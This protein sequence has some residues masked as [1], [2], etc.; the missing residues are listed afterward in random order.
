MK[1]ALC[2]LLFTA[3]LVAI[4]TQYYAGL[5]NGLRY[6]SALPFCI[7]VPRRVFEVSEVVSLLTNCC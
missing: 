4:D 7:Y 6:V 1:R 2:A 5:Q 3:Q